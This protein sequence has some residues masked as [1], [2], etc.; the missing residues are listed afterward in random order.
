MQ[1]ESKYLHDQK[2]EDCLYLN[3]YSTSLTSSMPVMVWIHGG[4]Y[5]AG[6]GSMYDGSYLAMKDVVLVTLNYR[7]DIFGF[8][9]TE[10]DKIPGNY[11]MLDQIAAL[12][13]VQE[14][15]ANFGGDPKSVTI[16]GQSAGAGS[17]SLLT[18]SPLAKGLF[19]R[20]IMESGSSL[21][22]WS[23]TYPGNALSP[24]VVS[25]LVG[26]A[27]QCPDIDN[28]ADLLTCLQAVD[29]QTLMNT[30]VAVNTAIAA[31]LVNP[32]TPRVET[33]YGFLP[34]SPLNLLRQGKFND[35]AS[36][37]G[38]N[39]DEMGPYMMTFFNMSNIN[40]DE[41]N[42]VMKIFI[43]Q[44]NELQQDNLLKWID[45]KYKV[46]ES[47]SLVT[48]SKDIVDG[49]TFVGPSVVEIR[50]VVQR[51]SRNN[52]FMYR[53]NYKNSFS[54]TPDYVGAG[55]GEELMSVFNNSLHQNH[56]RTADDRDMSTQMIEMWTNFAKTGDPTSSVPPGGAQWKPYTLSDEA[57]LQINKT[58]TLGD[59]S[60][61]SRDIVNFYLTF[62]QSLDSSVTLNQTPG[63]VG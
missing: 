55:H 25:R 40:A 8:L 23:R 29:S 14:N 4:G 49:F 13:W 61:V 30:S 44:F 46:N 48:L 39:N 60:Q 58:S 5:F 47:Q 9:S 10:D 18:L 12:S 38:V 32:Y 52:H 62:M 33:T 24:R 27:L 19:H 3:I 63:V 53:F 54:N 7:L 34:D 15:I 35:V 22:P 21:N 59:L 28:T 42:R 16:F 1:K 51:S 41:A 45:S 26:T 2:S 50:E 31:P 11:G 37:R 43:A 6:S 56:T 36:I 57:F 20:A 17:V